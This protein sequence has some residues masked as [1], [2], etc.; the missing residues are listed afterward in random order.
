MLKSTAEEKK[1]G[2]GPKEGKTA[3][4]SILVDKKSVG[5]S[6]STMSVLRGTLQD[7]MKKIEKLNILVKSLD[8]SFF[9]PCVYLRKRK[10]TKKLT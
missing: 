8:L 1:G 7:Y 6:G 5:F 3:V 4:F 10:R 2:G 9:T